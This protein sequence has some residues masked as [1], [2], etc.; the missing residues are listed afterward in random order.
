MGYKL[1]INLKIF[2]DIE[3]F[4]GPKKET[5]DTVTLSWNGYYGVWK[6]AENLA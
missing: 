2:A 5:C 6:N 4:S 1:W 3:I